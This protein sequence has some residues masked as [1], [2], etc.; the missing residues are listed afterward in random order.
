MYMYACIIMCMY[1]LNY[2]VLFRFKVDM[3]SFP[4]IS[5]IN[6][7][8]NGLE[9]FQQASPTQQPDCPPELK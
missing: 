2:C 1:V 9:A 3:S 4:T 6:Q 8:L 5:R 7:T